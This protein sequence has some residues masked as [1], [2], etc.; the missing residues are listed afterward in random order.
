[1]NRTV[2]VLV[3]VLLPVLVIGCGGGGASGESIHAEEASSVGHDDAAEREEERAREEERRYDPTA[4]RPVGTTTQPDL[5]GLTTYNPT[6]VHLQHAAE[7]REHAEQH[8]SAAQAHA[9]FEEQHCGQF[10]AESRVTCPLIGQ[11]VGVT[12]VSRGARLELADGVDRSAF[13]DH[14]RCHLEFAATEELSAADHCPL[15]VE[16]TVLEADGDELILVAPTAAAQ[17]RL[18]ALL[19]EDVLPADEP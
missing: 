3:P 15:F 6:A 19:R 13:I 12:D 4:E 10:P 8:R 9:R 17:E 2:R 18:R 1:M 16:G 5:Y 11:V 14:V 7:H